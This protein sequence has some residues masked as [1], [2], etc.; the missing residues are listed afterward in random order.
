MSIKEIIHAVNETTILF[1]IK[2]MRIISNNCNITLKSRILFTAL[3]MNYFF[4]WHDFMKNSIKILFNFLSW[5]KDM[6]VFHCFCESFYKCRH[7]KQIS[8]V[9]LFIFLYLYFQRAFRS[10]LVSVESI[11]T[12]KLFNIFSI[13]RFLWASYLKNY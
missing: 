11:Q 3:C 13:S 6:N 5:A 8:A 4:N 10:N 2:Y 9:C 12:P 7:A 1:F